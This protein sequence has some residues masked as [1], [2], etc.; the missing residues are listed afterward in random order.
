MPI[1]ISGYIYPY[2]SPDLK[3]IMCGKKEKKDEFFK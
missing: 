1:F 3:F 2:Y